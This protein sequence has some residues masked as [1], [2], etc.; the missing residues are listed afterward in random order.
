MDTVA[1]LVLMTPSLGFVDLSVINGEVIVRDG[2]L[3]TLDLQVNCLQ[4]RILIFD[5]CVPR[6]HYPGFCLSPLG[7]CVILQPFVISKYSKDYLL[8]IPWRHCR[9]SVGFSR[10]PPAA[11]THGRGPKSFPVH[12]PKTIVVSPESEHP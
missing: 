10:A 11:G 9:N 5:I 8:C 12:L 3:L 4:G 7:T 2:K 6:T 1:G